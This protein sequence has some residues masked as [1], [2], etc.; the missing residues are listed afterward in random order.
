MVRY[1]LFTVQIS[2]QIDYW[3]VLKPRTHETLALW[4]SYNRCHNKCSE[5]MVISCNSVVVVLGYIISLLKQKLVP[6]IVLDK[7]YIM[8][9]KAL[10][11]QLSYEQPRQLPTF[12][13]I[14]MT[15]QI[16]TPR[17]RILCRH[18]KMLEILDLAK[19]YVHSMPGRTIM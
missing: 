6:R 14:G 18:G 5:R 13:L 4:N 16:R 11:L 12:M 2:L 3:A 19:N 10:A 7:R 15:T 17:L 1:V 8:L 9:V